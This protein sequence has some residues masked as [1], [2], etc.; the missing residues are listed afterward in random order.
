MQQTDEQ[1]VPAPVTLRSIT[2][3]RFRTEQLNGWASTVPFGQRRLRIIAALVL[4]SVFGFG[5]YW[6]STAHLGGAAVG[7]GR[8]IA[9]GNNRIVQ[10]L[11]GGILT[12]ILVK[13]GDVVAVG[14]PLAEMDTTATISQLTAT[15]VQRATLAAQ[16]ARWRAAIDGAESFTVDPEQLAPMQDNT[17][18]IEA[19]KSQQGAFA[20]TLAVE[21]KQLSMLDAK[22]ESAR[23]DIESQKATIVAIDQQDDLIELE[24]SDLNKL[25]TSG[26]TGKSRVLALERTM[27]QIDAQRAI[28]KFAIAKAESDIKALSEEKDRTSL[29]YAEEANKNF[30]LI[31][32]DMNTTEDVEARLQDRLTRSII[33]SPADGVVFRVY[34]QTEGSVLGPG[35]S[36]LEIFPDREAMSVEVV[37]QPKDITSVHKGQTVDVVFQSDH[38]AKLVPIEGTVD[39]ISTDTIVNEQS[40]RTMY[41]VRASINKGQDE[42]RVLPGNTAEVYFQ[43]EP[44]TLVQL[45]AEPLTRFAFKAF[46][47]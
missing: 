34:K 27:A 35:E 26:L 11:E 37:V 22:I 45:L 20:A 2:S 13:Q 25:L 17:R 19:V 43:T 3:E 23:N 31:Q 12:R 36:F 32:R 7:V 47:G 14:T 18:I 15:Q 39:Y 16:L 21:K 33:R 4:V 24:H 29:T 38:R 10:H 42:R 8:V 40:G 28:A 44:K 6:A 30:A 46:T 1:Q 41:I 9:T 5:G